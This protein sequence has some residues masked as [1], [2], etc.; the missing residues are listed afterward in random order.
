MDKNAE[1]AKKVA[2]LVREAGGRTFYVG[3]FVRDSILGRESKDIDIEIHGITPKKLAEILNSIG[4]PIVMGASFG[5]FGLRGY[6]LDMAMPRCETADGRGRKDFEDFVDPF[7]GTEKAARRRDFT[8]N[9]L[10]QDVLTG[11]IIDAFGGMEDLKRGVIRHVN[12]A[13]FAEDPLRVLRAAQFAA[14]FGFQVADETLAISRR[15]DLTALARERIEGEL[16]KAFGQ[17]P[18]PSVFFEELK[19]MNQLAYWFP[20]MESL[21][22]EPDA[23]Q[24]AMRTMDAAA[25][26]RTEAKYPLGL[27]YAAACPDGEALV[28]PVTRETRTIDYVSN[29]NALRGEIGRLAAQAGDADTLSELYDRS[30]SP[31]DLILLFRADRL[32]AGEDPAQQEGFLRG[33]LAEYRRRMALPFVKGQDLMAA[34]FEPGPGMGRALKL[35]HALRLAAVPKEEALRKTCALLMKEKK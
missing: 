22:R 12:D 10:M 20:A 9:A 24:R 23:W 8:M 19:K 32:A 26:M 5:I 16:Q 33:M 27:L 6:E 29:M 30:V 15:M 11:E 13:T 2:A 18:R 1:M 17:A 4:E 35:A 21:S 3:G 25:R 28:H 7:I 31:E 14:R 34:G